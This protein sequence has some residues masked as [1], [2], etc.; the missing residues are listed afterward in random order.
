MPHPPGSRKQR[1]PSLICLVLVR[2][3]LRE[4]AISAG[5][6]L[7]CALKPLLDKQLPEAGSSLHYPWLKR[8]TQGMYRRGPAA[9]IPGPG[10]GHTA[11]RPHSPCRTVRRQP[12]GSSIMNGSAGMWLFVAANFSEVRPARNKPRGSL[13]SAKGGPAH[14]LAISQT[15]NICDRNSFPKETTLKMGM[16]RWDNH[17]T[18]LASQGL[19]G[20]RMPEFTSQVPHLSTML[21]WACYLYLSELLVGQIRIIQTYCVSLY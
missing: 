20:V 4:L 8:C 15:M 5:V 16:S 11:L 10:E 3:S 9:G 19:V 13:Q 7:T 12:S 1:L 14:T 6:L 2:V 18:H 17:S 21:S